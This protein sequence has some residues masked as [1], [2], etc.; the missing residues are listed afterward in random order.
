VNGTTSNI[1]FN[2]TGAWN[3]WTTMNVNIT[4]N[5]NTTNTIRFASNGQDLGNIDE[6]TVP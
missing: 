5:N 3:T 2:P 4:L 1:T 6:I